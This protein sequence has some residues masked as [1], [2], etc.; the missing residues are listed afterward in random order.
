MSVVD[1]AKYC[2][3]ADKFT[4]FTVSF[5]IEPVFLWHQETCQLHPTACNAY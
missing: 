1:L 3:G 5:P 2:R 4:F